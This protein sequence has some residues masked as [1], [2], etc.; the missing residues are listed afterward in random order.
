MLSTFKNVFLL[1]CFCLLATA[2]FSQYF[3][4]TANGVI[5]L[6]TQSNKLRA[7]TIFS[8]QSLNLQG[9]ITAKLNGT[10]ST[11][12]LSGNYLGIMS[13]GK[14]F[15]GYSS[16]TK[17]N[18]GLSW[19][20]T[21]LTIGTPLSIGKLLTPQ[22]LI[23]TNGTTPSGNPGGF[24]GNSSL[25]S[26]ALLVDFKPLPGSTG[27]SQIWFV[28][29]SHPSSYAVIQNGGTGIN[30]GGIGWGI[31]MYDVNGGRQFTVNGDSLIYRGIALT[32]NGFYP[33]A[34]FKTSFS[35]NAAGTGYFTNSLND[36]VM[37]IQ[38]DTLAINK[39]LY[40]TSTLAVS[41][42]G[43]YI[44]SPRYLNTYLGSAK[45]TVST[46]GTGI[47]VS[48]DGTDQCGTITITTGATVSS[49]VPLCSLTYYSG[50]FPNNSFVVFTPAPSSVV[51]FGQ[52]GYNASQLALYQ[53]L[54]ATA[55]TTGF[56]VNTWNPTLITANT[57]YKINYIVKGR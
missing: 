49:P 13:A 45:P 15:I 4:S 54:S 3:D 39:P 53:T 47:T 10:D 25:K 32:K 26:T 31:N 28:D 34:N 56:T 5:S 24:Y 51:G 16:A 42:A 37:T 44:S 9:V 23:N 40:L 6:H 17:P 35:G 21:Q 1:A 29:S 11:Y 46:T 2:G 12:V 38:P 43:G 22:V 36:T 27:P 41:S 50:A 48:V 14:G 30:G 8:D 7:R 57:T 18:Y 55:T 20:S 19:D 33:N 52:S